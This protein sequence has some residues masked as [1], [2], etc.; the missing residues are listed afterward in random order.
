MNAAFATSL[1]FI[2]LGLL[3]ARSFLTVQFPGPE[4]LQGPGLCGDWPWVPIKT[5]IDIDC[6]FYMCR[7]S[8]V[9]H[10]SAS[11]YCFC[12]GGLWPGSV[13]LPAMLAKLF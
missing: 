11:W 7:L 2:V 4:G 8:R 13:L 5:G 6:V 12:S 3:P 10:A 9:M 1:R